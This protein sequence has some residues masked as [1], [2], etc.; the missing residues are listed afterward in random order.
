MASRKSFAETSPRIAMWRTTEF[1]MASQVGRVLCALQQVLQD[2]DF[3]RGKL[4]RTT[5]PWT[6]DMDVDVVRDAAV[7]D[8][9]DAVSERDGFGHVMRH[10]DRGEGLIVPDPFEQPLH[11]YP[12]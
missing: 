11:R 3:Q 5:P 6:R 12:C 9:E 2:R 10:Q 8:H 1:M 7:L 4:G